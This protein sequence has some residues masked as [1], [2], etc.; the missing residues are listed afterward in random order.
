MEKTSIPIKTKVAIYWIMALSIPLLYW[1]FPREYEMIRPGETSGA[2][3]FL[4]L[5]GLILLSSAILLLK[6]KKVGY[7]ITLVVL[8]V[9]LLC[10]VLEWIRIFLVAIEHPYCLFKTSLRCERISYETQT[11]ARSFRV[12]TFLTFLL[13]IPFLLLLLDR[14]KFWKISS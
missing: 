6:K 5:P 8:F 14:K 12:N 7:Y 10:I 4:F 11:L 1:G 13:L 3:Y 9:G 2:F